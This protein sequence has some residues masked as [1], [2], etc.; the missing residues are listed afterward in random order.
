MAIENS[1]TS[2][3]STGDY[4]LLE[5]VEIY[6]VLTMKIDIVIRILETRRAKDKG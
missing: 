3:N 4:N 1:E 5:Y 2:I 6:Y